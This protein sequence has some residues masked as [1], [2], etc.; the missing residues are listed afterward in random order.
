MPAVGESWIGG[1]NTDEEA[2]WA[3]ERQ[4]TTWADGHQERG[5]RASEDADKGFQMNSVED[6]LVQYLGTIS[7][8]QRS[9][10]ELIAY[11]DQAKR[12]GNV[13]WNASQTHDSVR[14]I[15]S[16]YGIKVTDINRLE[17]FMR[18]PMHKIGWVMHYT[19]DND[20]QVVVI[21]AGKPGGTS[22]KYYLYQCSSAEQAKKICSTF[23]EAFALVHSR[24]VLESL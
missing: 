14:L 13:A 22:F 9:T 23:G 10:E 12:T 21:E 17:I 24:A 8:I 18:V 20:Q 4:R 3:A 16:K 2:F 15:L 1:Q 7:G 5:G 11:V 19:E 6:A